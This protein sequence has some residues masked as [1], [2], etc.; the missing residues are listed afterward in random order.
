MIT[1]TELL[2]DELDSVREIAY[3]T[4]PETYGPILPKGQIH[5]MLDLFYSEESLISNIED[6]QHFLIAKE[7]GKPLA[8]ASYK[9]G[10][11]TSD[12]TKIPKIYVLPDAQGK[13]LGK[14]LIGHIAKLAFASG[15]EKLTLNVN[16]KNGALAF[17]QKLGFEI[18][19]SED[20]PIG[21]GY[22]MEDYIMEKQLP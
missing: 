18:V 21:E 5:Y 3:I 16:R 22:L 14:M 12:A 17:Y 19:G 13:G 11:P 20:I 6:G 4:W 8:F 15:S 7:H 9:L 2:P 1:I 10:F